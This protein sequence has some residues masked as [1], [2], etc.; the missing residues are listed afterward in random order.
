M[1][2]NLSR[3]DF[4]RASASLTGAAL[5]GSYGLVDRVVA[6][7][8]RRSAI[9]QVTLGK[10]GIKLSRLGIGTGVNNGH[11]Q[12]TAGKEAF[13]KLVRHAMD[14]GITYVDTAE[15]YETFNWIGDAVKGTPRE[16]LFIQSKMWAEPSDALAA[17]DDQRK[18]LNTDYIDS[19]LVHCMTDPKWTDQH[20]RMTDAY[21]TA[22]DKKW[23]RARGV[24][25]H[26]LAALQDGVRSDWAQV[27]LV[28]V[29]PQ[30][31]YMDGPPRPWGAEMQTEIKPVLDSIQKMKQ[32]GR[33]VI[34]MK[35]YGNGSFKT[36]EERE[37]S[38]RF[39]M[40]NPNIDAIVIGFT[41]T[42]QIDETIAQ[43]NR[44]LAAA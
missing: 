33:G 16:K 24:S 32:M 42:Q 20:K 30:G 4:I 12:I 19:L 6:Q 28:R 9:D 43:M 5:L 27:H 29:N 31:A 38:M 36:V 44:A 34:G 8:T 23:I 18:R 17:I 41:S 14:Q 15:R 11:D 13:I 25:C 35:I 1:S 26:T 40:S 22:I 3:R 37:Q 21:N 39:A 2:Q 10:T 7:T